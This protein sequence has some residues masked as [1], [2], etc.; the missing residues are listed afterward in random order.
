MVSATTSQRSPALDTVHVWIREHGDS[1]WSFA[2]SRAPA[3]VAEDLVHDTLVAALQSAERFEQRS[4]AETWL[5]SI[6]SRKIADYYRRRARDRAVIERVIP[7]RSPEFGE[8]G[9]WSAPPKDWA[10]EG[11]SALI[12]YLDS[13]RD[14][15]PPVLRD[16]LELR[17][18]RQLPGDAVCKVLG[19]TPTNLWTRLHR[20]RMMLRSCIEARVRAGR[21]Q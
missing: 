2:L 18:I 8:D 9:C 7:E 6:L 1:L 21:G 4:S 11:D 3:G 20:A 17:E 12:A 14:E 5:L 15:L 19:I 10:G 16:T 13:C